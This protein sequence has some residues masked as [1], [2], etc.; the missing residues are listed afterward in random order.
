MKRKVSRAFFH[1]INLVTQE[2]GSLVGNELPLKTRTIPGL[3]MYFDG[4][5]F[6]FSAN[7]GVEYGVPAANV[8]FVKYEI[9]EVKPS[10][11][12]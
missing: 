4:T 5:V 3:E 11:K 2:Y 9:E 6:T 12:A 1:D 8:K 10:K 7:G